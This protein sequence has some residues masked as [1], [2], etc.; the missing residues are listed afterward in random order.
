MG[1]SDQGTFPIIADPW[2]ANKA[3]SGSINDRVAVGYLTNGTNLPAVSDLE[4]E[5]LF[6][7]SGDSSVDGRR[8]RWVGRL[9]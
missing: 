4:A 9:L 7:G 3:L 1:S 8:V 5:A 2:W 6:E